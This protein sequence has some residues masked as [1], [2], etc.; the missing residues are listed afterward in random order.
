MSKD[1][2]KIMVKIEDEAGWHSMIE[3]SEERLVIMDIHQDWC[4]PTEA[5][6]PTLS[7]V[8]AVLL[9]AANLQMMESDHLS[10]SSLR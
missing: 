1:M 3:S 2:M 6:H 9:P 4:G 8:F 7:R 5:I 10:V